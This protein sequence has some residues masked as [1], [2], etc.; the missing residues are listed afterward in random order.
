L[1]ERVNINKLASNILVPPGIP[2]SGILIVGANE[3][4]ASISLSVNENF[5]QSVLYNV[6]GV[7]PG[8]SK[9]NEAIIFSAHY[10]HVDKDPAGARGGIFNGANDDASGTTAVMLLARYFS[11]L[12]NNERTIVFCLFAGE[13]L[14]MMGSR[15]FIPEIEPDSIKAMINIEM[16]G[17]PGIGRNAF[18]ITGS[19][20]SDL[21]K[22]FRKNIAGKGAL[23]KDEDPRQRN[24][25]ERSD[26]YVFALE[27]I[28]AHSIMSSDDSDPCYHQ[29]CDDAKNIDFDNMVNIIIA[30]ANGSKTLISGQDTPKRI[31]L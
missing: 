7:L 24:L 28:P 22:I 18:F 25:F 19:G 20:H 4:P 23:I 31:K 3:E 10:D 29:P 8:R 11:S 6:V 14:G 16:I 5:I 21:W 13:E 27:G 15:A 26:N 12:K 2:S 17:A 1:S 9:P 30:I